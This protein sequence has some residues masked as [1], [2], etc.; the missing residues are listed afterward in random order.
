MNSENTPTRRRPPSLLQRKVA[1]QAAD[2]CMEHTDRHITIPELA[3][4]FHISPTHLKSAFQAVF[5]MPLYHYVRHAK[6]QWAARQLAETQLPVLAIANSCGYEN[7]SK[8]SH[9]FRLHWGESPIQYRRG[10][11]E[12][13]G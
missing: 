2:Y 10:L 5:G 9:A 3:K 6:M 13:E 8:F 1:Q 11:Q 4:A 12:N 7:A